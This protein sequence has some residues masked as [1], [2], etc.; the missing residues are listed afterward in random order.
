VCTIFARAFSSLLHNLVESF[1]CDPE[2]EERQPKSF[3]ITCLKSNIIRSK[4]N[5]Y[6]RAFRE[7]IE[8]ALFSDWCDSVCLFLL[9][10]LII[11]FIC[12]TET[13]GEYS[14]VFSFA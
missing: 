4:V 5:D 6:Q 1:F 7:I 9:L 11:S 12:F 2:M 3:P 13:A 10:L 8:L 14:L